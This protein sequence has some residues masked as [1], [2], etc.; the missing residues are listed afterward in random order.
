MRQ[1]NILD[2]DGNTYKTVKIG[3]QVWMAEN[4]KVTKYR[5]GDAIPNVKRAERWGDL[6][7]GA[8]CAYGNK[9]ANAKIYGLL[10]NWFAVNDPRGLAPEG[11]H[12]PSDDEWQT[13]ADYP[14]GSKIADNKLK[15]AGTAHWKSP[16]TGSTN[17]SG[18]TALPG[19]CRDFSDGYFYGLWG[20]A[21][22]W[23][24]SEYYAY[25]VWARSLFYHYA[26]IGRYYYNKRDGFSVRC[27]RD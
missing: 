16:N 7:T 15:E 22:F 10:Y 3:E 4:L 23:S 14:G 21:L 13:L 26:E 12:V 18:F 19:G 25:G 9:V 27:V 1:D 6:T 2:I 20:N 5:N 8:R 17:E 24:A 11:W